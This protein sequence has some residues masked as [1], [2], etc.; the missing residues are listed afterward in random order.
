MYGSILR[1]CISSPSPQQVTS[2]YLYCQYR[3]N[4]DIHCCCDVSG[5]RSVWTVDKWSC[6][7]LPELLLLSHSVRMRQHSHSYCCFCAVSLSIFAYVR[8][9]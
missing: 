4:V 6:G 2:N 9:I 5:N 3:D 7:V 8:Y 1:F